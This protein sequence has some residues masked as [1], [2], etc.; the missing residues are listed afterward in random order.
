[1]IRV[2]YGDVGVQV[3]GED[4]IFRPAFI[5]ALKLGSPTEIVKL[6]SDLHMLDAKKEIL[7]SAYGGYYLK[8]FVSRVLPTA[9]YVLL[10]C[11][12]KDAID[13]VGTLNGAKK[14]KPGHLP[15]DDII[16]LAKHLLKHMMFGKPDESSKAGSK[17][18]SGEFNVAELVDI[19]MLKLRLS[20]KEAL[21]L[22]MTRFQAMIKI[23]FPDQSSD[24]PSDQ[25]YDDCMEWSEKVKQARIKAGE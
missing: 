21:N 16:V 10:C 2:N 18:F 3:G 1:M 23:E 20:E 7:A 12:D 24:H 6:F 17:E 8:S 9:C 25:D 5:N 4:F 13:L 11:C 19:A 22:S 15:I 14:Y